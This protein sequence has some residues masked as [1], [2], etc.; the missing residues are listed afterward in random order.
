MDMVITRDGAAAVLT[1]K[2]RLSSDV[3]D[4]FHEKLMGVMDG[5]PGLLVVDMAE[6]TFITSSG[7]RGLILAAKRSRGEGTAIRLSGLAE[8][9]REVFEV[10]G[11]VKVFPIHATKAEALAAGA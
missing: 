6:L 2:G 10:S 9:V 1:L 3:A 11:L 8:N 7:L 4:A 5:K